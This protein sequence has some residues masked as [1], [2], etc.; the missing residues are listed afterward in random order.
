[1]ARKSKMYR[2]LS[3][4]GFSLAFKHSLW[5]GP[6]HL[7]WV[8][9]GFF[10]EQYKRFYFKDIQSVTLRQTNRRVIWTLILGAFLL[11]FGTVSLFAEK[12]AYVSGGMAILFAILLVVQW[13]KGSGCTVFL[14]TAVQTKKLSNL[15]RM[16]KAIKIMDR[17][18]AAAE[19]AQGPL[20][21]QYV[22]NIHRLEARSGADNEMVTGTPERHLPPQ[23]A[24]VDAG[25]YNSRLHLI[26]FGLL[27]TAGFL[28]IAQ[29][30]LKLIPLAVV[31]ILGLLCTL[32][33]AII[34]LVRW[35]SRVRGSL[36]SHASWLSLIFAA[37]HALSAYGMLIAAS[38]R[39][40]HSGVNIWSL[41][42][43]FFQLQMENQPI[44]ETI[45]VGI[46]LISVGLGILGLIAT[47]TYKQSRPIQQRLRPI[48]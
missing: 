32:A 46:A 15:V 31:D 40:H 10:Q 30:W 38:I 25:A 2:K 16:R 42:K 3:G 11:L 23:A 29:L 28:R 9:A 18:K 4:G 34:V 6:D 14:Q 24:G 19:A 17:I 43:A 48:A 33:L 21:E 47:L 1:M 41:F 45:T 5:Q 44:I 26:L 27:L 37:V 22:A 7:L 35:H 39:L 36:L 8:E 13:L 20:N 12:P